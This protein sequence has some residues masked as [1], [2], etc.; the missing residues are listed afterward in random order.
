MRQSAEGLSAPVWAAAL[1]ILLA[2]ACSAYAIPAFPGAEG[3]GANST[4]GRGG[5]VYHVTSLDDSN[6]AGTLR[7]GINN[8][9]TGGRTIVFD[10]SGTI[11]LTSALKLIQNKVTIA[12]QTAPGQGIC[13]RNYEFDISD[14]NS[15]TRHIRSRVGTDA[16]SGA[17][18]DAIGVVNSAYDI[19]N[20]IVDHC[21]ASWGLDEGLSVAKLPTNVTVQYCYI[22]EAL[23]LAGH[24]FGSLLRPSVDCNL[25][26]HHNLYVDNYSRNPRPG[27]YNNEILNLDF[28]N[29]VIYNWGEQAGY[30]ENVEPNENVNM[31]YVGNYLIAGPSTSVDTLTNAFRGGSTYTAIY[32][33]GNKIDGDREGVLDGNDTGWGMFG[34]SYT[35]A[36]GSFSFPAVYTQTADAALTTVLANGGAF[37]ANRDTVD[38][39]VAAQVRSYGTAGALYNSVAQAG[40]YP[41]YPVVTRD[42]NFD[43]DHDGMPNTWEATYGLNPNDPNDRNGDF[44]A[45][46]YTNLEEYLNSLAPIPSPKTIVW[47]GGSAGRYELIANWDIPW[48]PTLSGKTEIDSGKATVGY[49]GQEAGTLYV[50]N[51]TGGSAEL[52][53]T[54]G[55]TLNVAYGLYV[56]KAANAAGT[57][58][59][60]GGSLGSTLQFIGD[61]GKGTFNQ[62]GGT[63]TTAYLGLGSAPAASGTYALNGGSVDALFQTVGNSGTGI[64]NQSA[65]TNTGYEL[66]VGNAGGSHGTYT[67]SGG[68]LGMGAADVGSSGTGMFNQSGGTHTMIDSLYLGHYYESRGT[69][70]LSGGVMTVG[71]SITVGVAVDSQGTLS[72]TGGSLT[73]TGSIILA[74]DLVS[75][76]S[77]TV[78]KA[79][80]VQAGGLT[81]HSGGGRSTQVKMEL[82]ANGHSLIGTTGAAS[83]GGALDLQSLNNYRPDQGNTF[84]LITSTGMGGNFDSIATNLQGLLR[85]NRNDP[86]AGY[87]PAFS[88][89]VVG[90][91]YVVTFQGARAGDAGGDNRVDGTDLAELGAA[92]LKTEGTYTW[93]NCDF[94]GD[95]IV[96]GTDLAALGANWLWEGAWPGP[97]PAD[98]PLPEPATL[99]LLALGGLGVVKRRGKVK[100]H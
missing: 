32:Q 22:E 76:A 46:G 1:V 37:P 65:G 4:G 40:G 45:D 64:F 29:N 96:D 23:N 73:A 11:T 71:G 95:G 86:N 18:P 42:A 85:I 59:L 24:G 25:S 33:S 13:L 83:L 5:D 3:Y 70:S 55:G 53:I 91:D 97:A 82:D 10:I 94:N 47:T 72:L 100:A 68:S 75:T 48:Q 51:T 56:G 31:N 44:D 77:L 41:D 88:G 7:Y 16:N 81:I 20:I 6:T 30:S 90:A 2:L 66:L 43:T 69:Y 50:A 35:V 89:A 9:P 28:R 34:G 54:T 36:G 79:A 12:G 98:A 27:T 57:A 49:L 26:F 15:I 74:P 84:T 14:S 62:S 38:A 92:W 58:T 67:L 63:N 8:A 61:L 60:S 39:N 93:L 17:N 80:Y 78:A 21:S 52:A 19:S 87:R 99:A